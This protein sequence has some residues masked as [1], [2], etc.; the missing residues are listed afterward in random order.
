MRGAFS[1]I[2]SHVVNPAFD[3]R[4]E[5]AL[6]LGVLLIME[7]SQDTFYGSRIVVL[8]EMPPYSGLGEVRML[9]EFKK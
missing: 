5:L 8:D 1:N 4:Y 2:Y 3:A 7:P 6:R 9:V